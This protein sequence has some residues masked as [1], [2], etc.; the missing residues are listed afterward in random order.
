MLQQLVYLERCSI[1]RNSQQWAGMVVDRLWK[2]AWEMWQH[3]NHK[4]HKDNINK[5]LAQ[6]WKQVEQEIEIG[7]QKLQEGGHLSARM[8]SKS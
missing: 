2:I 3:R 6:L 5:E 1:E 7:T 4:E 8:T